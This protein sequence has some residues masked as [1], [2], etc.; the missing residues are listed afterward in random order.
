MQGPI[1]DAVRALFLSTGDNAKWRSVLRQPTAYLANLLPED[2]MRRNPMNSYSFVRVPFAVCAIAAACV[3]GG[4]GLAETT[5]VAASEAA[6][7]A[8]Q[9][10]QGKELEA[11]LQQDIAAAQMKAAEA[12]DSAEAGTQ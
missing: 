9:V 4:C 1:R 12:V 5:A 6:S 7:A 8:E 2:P 11:K 10:K 3:S